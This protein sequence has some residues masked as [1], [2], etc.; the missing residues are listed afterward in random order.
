VKYKWIQAHARSTEAV[1]QGEPVLFLKIVRVPVRKG[2]G[3]DY[4]VFATFQESI[5]KFMLIG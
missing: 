4:E 1:A 2:S 3:L 5:S